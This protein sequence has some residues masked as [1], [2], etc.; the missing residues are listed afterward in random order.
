[1]FSLYIYPFQ[2]QRIKN[3]VFMKACRPFFCRVFGR[4]TQ[5][6]AKENVIQWMFNSDEPFTH[7]N[8]F[9]MHSPFSFGTAP[10]CGYA[11]QDV[12]R[13]ISLQYQKH[14]Y[15][16][17]L[18]SGDAIF[19]RARTRCIVDDN[20]DP[21]RFFV[22]PL[23]LARHPE[24]I[25]SF[26]GAER[27]PFL[28]EILTDLI[29]AHDEEAPLVHKCRLLGMDQAKWVSFL[30]GLCLCVAQRLPVVSQAVFVIE[31]CIIGSC[32][33]DF[34]PLAG[35]YNARGVAVA[36]AIMEAAVEFGSIPLADL[37]LCL[38][39]QFLTETPIDVMKRLSIC[40]TRSERRSLEWGLR[41]TTKRI[42]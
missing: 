19:E 36:E 12:A 3:K 2:S 1:M 24:R 39:R 10:P 4:K 26:F 25:P 30:R 37:S 18:F 16:Y 40:T 28:I 21:S 29:R 27:S 5:G 33:S 42:S 17:A 8:T 23:V 14:V 22:H 35:D 9:L 38:Y 7:D 11:S 41:G 13:S 6:T 34:L 15:A 31:D 20:I 32:G